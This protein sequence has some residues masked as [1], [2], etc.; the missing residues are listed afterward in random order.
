[1]VQAT[2]K[3]IHFFDRHY[4][5]GAGW[6]TQ[7]FP[8]AFP[9]AV[10]RGAMGRKSIAG[11]ATP[12]YLYH[13]LVPARVGTMLPD[14]KLIALLRDPV[15]R[16]ISHWRVAHRK[17]WD[18]APDIDT[19]LD[20]EAVRMAAHAGR[21][22]ADEQYVDDGYF[23]HAYMARGRYAEQLT[24]W[25]DVFGRERVLVLK[26]ERLFEN[27]AAVYGEACSF[28]GLAADGRVGFDVHNIGSGKQVDDD[29]VRR[30]LREYFAPHNAALRT[31]LGDGFDWGY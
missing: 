20:R 14:V 16:A 11:E 21:L 27:P 25:F 6:Y 2:R 31:M 1:M 10:L 3:E 17:G 19:A 29:G 28:L 26:A 23:R 24:R 30:R 5:R 13:P 8:K 4:N 7:H 12:S 18:D 22:A 15:E 9:V